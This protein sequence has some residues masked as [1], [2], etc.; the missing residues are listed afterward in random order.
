MRMKHSTPGAAQHSAVKAA[1]RMMTIAGKKKKEKK[2]K[3]QEKKRMEKRRAKVT[4]RGRVTK[5]W[6]SCS[7]RLPLTEGEVTS[8]I[9][10]RWWSVSLDQSAGSEDPGEDEQE[11]DEPTA[12][13]STEAILPSHG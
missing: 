2:R 12:G 7:G 6:G 5:A 1:E 9:H 13:D 11:D 10:D 8:E 4:A 3:K